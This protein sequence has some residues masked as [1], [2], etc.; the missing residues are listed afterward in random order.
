MIAR[1]ADC[2]ILHN[3][4]GG[5]ENEF[6]FLKL[7]KRE[8]VARLRLVVILG[9]IGDDT[10]AHLQLHVLCGCNLFVV[11]VKRLKVVAHNSSLGDD[12]GAEIEVECG[13][14]CRRNHV[15]AQ[16]SLETHSACQH[17]DNLGVACQFGGEEDYGDEY[18]Q[19][20]EQ[21]G[22]VGYEIGVVVEHNGAQRCMIGCELCQVLVDVEYNGYRDDEGNGIEICTDKFHYDISVHTLDEFQL[23][24]KSQLM[25]ELKFAEFQFAE[26]IQ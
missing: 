6:L 13:D 1:V 14:E 24:Q 19:R 3:I 20:T 9:Y 26:H 18:E 22:E 17:G 25:C 7:V 23:M 15:G 4:G 11:L 12:V 2:V 8:S 16:E 5:V 21:V 10:L